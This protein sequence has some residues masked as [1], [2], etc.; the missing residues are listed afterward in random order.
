MRLPC[1]WMQLH[2]IR[3][4]NMREQHNYMFNIA[5]AYHRVQSYPSA[6]KRAVIA[7][8]IAKNAIGCDCDYIQARERER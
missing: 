7:Y 4:D 8:A 5:R 3:C 2:A 6:S 1:E